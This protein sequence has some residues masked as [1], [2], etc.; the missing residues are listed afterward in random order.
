MTPMRTNLQERYELREILGR[1]GMGVVYKALDT[2]MKREV[3]LKT[4]IDIDNPASADLC[5]KDN[6]QGVYTVPNTRT[7][8][9][10]RV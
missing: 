3:A 8:Y 9:P 6:R 10:N 7:F 5:H 4:I 1:G 2:L